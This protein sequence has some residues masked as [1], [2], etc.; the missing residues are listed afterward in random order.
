MKQRSTTIA[1]VLLFALLLTIA[2]ITQAAPNN[3]SFRWTPNPPGDNVTTYV[4]HWG[5]ASHA[6]TSQTNVGSATTVMLTGLPS[7]TPLFF[8]LTATNADGLGS[9]YSAELVH[10]FPPDDM[11]VTTRPAKDFTQTNVTLV[12]VV[13]NLPTQFSA[14][15]E[16]CHGTNWGNT[17]VYTTPV[18]T[19]TD[20]NYRME[21]VIATIQ[22]NWLFR[23]VV[24]NGPDV[25]ITGTRAFRT[26][27]PGAPTQIR[28]EVRIIQT[29]S[30]VNPVWKE[31]M[32]A[33][34]LRDYPTSGMGYFKAVMNSTPVTEHTPEMD[35]P[36]PP[37]PT[38][39]A[40]EEEEQP[41]MLRIPDS[42]GAPPLPR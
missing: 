24:T 11:L 38:I 20:S 29:A 6:Y 30:L 39:A 42:S 31:V 18:V 27:P 35:I 33:S 12:G 2:T 19:V 5:T 32:T 14:F 41:V 13:S 7:G 21:A 3:V 36:I 8:A 28:Y 37:A 22:T 23:L 4:V 9:E 17:P 40:R 15:F 34:V 1:G 26:I 10:T 16:Y 25:Y